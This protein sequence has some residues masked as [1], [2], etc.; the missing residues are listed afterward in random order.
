MH[1]FLIDS[2]KTNYNSSW[3]NGYEAIFVQEGYINRDFDWHQPP[4]TFVLVHG[5]WADSSFW[6][7]ISEEL[8]NLGHIVYTPDLPGHGQD[9]NKNVTHSIITKSVVDYIHVHDLTNIILVGHSFGGSVIQK[10]AERIPERIRRLVFWNAFV[11]ND[12]ESLADQFPSSIQQFFL[13]LANQ[14]S[15]NTILLPFPFFRDIFVNLAD[16]TLAQYLY[17]QITPE[18]AKP[19]GEKLNLKKFFQLKIPKSY[20]NLLEDTATPPG[21]FG[22]HPHLSSRLGIYRLIQGHGDHF[23]TAQSNPKK[24]AHLI[25]KAGRD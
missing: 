7:G 1:N 14:S 4:L 8:R 11:I 25:I 17:K 9:K 2:Y 12:G 10:V 23:S 21:E 22:W 20:I 19:F 3:G 24:V 16:H 18:P 15:D 13:G 5:S 6:R